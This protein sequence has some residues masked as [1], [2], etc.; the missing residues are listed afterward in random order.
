MSEV[1]KKKRDPGTYRLTL[2]HEQSGDVTWE[3][4]MIPGD[5]VEQIAKVLRDMMP[6]FVAAH[7]VQQAYAGIET[8]F[9]GLQA[10]IEEAKPKR[11]RR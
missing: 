10:A 11:A 9:D 3:K 4:T 2:T 8:A 6:F 5:H 7:G 1:A